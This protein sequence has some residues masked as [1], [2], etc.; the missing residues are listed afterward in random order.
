MGGRRLAGLGRTAGEEPDVAP[1][2]SKALLTV[3]AVG[4]AF[5]GCGDDGQIVDADSPGSTVVYETHTLE[6]FDSDGH[7][8]GPATGE[9]LPQG[10]SD[11]E[12]LRDA[13]S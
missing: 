6:V 1:S 5:G 9:H 2:R 10:D 3:V 11:E 8:V 13:A 4:L 7:P 12:L